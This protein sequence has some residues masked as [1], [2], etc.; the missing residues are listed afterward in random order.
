MEK[1]NEIMH[2]MCLWR[3]GEQINRT[4]ENDAKMVSR[5]GERQRSREWREEPESISVLH[6]GKQRQP[7]QVFKIPRGVRPAGTAASPGLLPAGVFASVPKGI[8]VPV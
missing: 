4:Y 2:G 5:T 8:L 3:K 7:A 1:L 6:N